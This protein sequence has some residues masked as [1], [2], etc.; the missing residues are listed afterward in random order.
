MDVNLAVM[1]PHKSHTL[2]F[3]CGLGPRKAPAMINKISRINNGG[4]LESRAGLIKNR[5]CASQI[6]MNCASFIRVRRIHFQR[7]PGEDAF[8]DVLDDTRIHPEDY[9]LARKMAADAIEADEE[10]DE[11][12]NPSIHVQDLMEGGVNRLDSLLLEDYADE[13]ERRLGEPKRIA[14]NEIKDELKRP[15]NESRRRFGPPSDDRIFA[16]LTGMTDETLRKDMLIACRVLRM[17]ERVVRV[18]VGTNLEGIIFPQNLTDEPTMGRT[19]EEIGIREGQVLKCRVLEILKEKMSVELSAKPAEVDY[20]PSERVTRD[21]FFDHDCEAKDVSIRA[22]S[23]HQ[24]WLIPTQTD[25]DR[26]KKVV[27]KVMKLSHP[28]YFMVD[29]AAAEKMLENKEIGFYLLRPSSKGPRQ[30]SITW[31]VAE[32]KASHIGLSLLINKI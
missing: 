19:P 32:G 5:I 3:V 26:K 1:Y 28:K 27:K 7:R 30:L 16:M 31:K 25:E 11:E 21:E 22:G 18:L 14:L 2:Q 13:L 6:F 24:T 17:S 4:R 23:N 9:E 10:L 29:S 20:G 8:L 15:Y 12:E